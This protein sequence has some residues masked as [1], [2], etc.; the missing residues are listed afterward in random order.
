MPRLGPE[1]PERSGARMDAYLVKPSK[2]STATGWVRPRPS[3]GSRCCR[4]R[5]DDRPDDHG[6]DSRRGGGQVPARV[7]LGQL[8]VARSVSTGQ[9]RRTSQP[10][11]CQLGEADSASNGQPPEDRAS[12]HGQLE[13]EAKSQRMML[14]DGTGRDDEQRQHDLETNHRPCS[15]GALG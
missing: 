10:T 6:S 14:G 2:V 4:A 8:G 1:A 12:A 13:L 7:Y 15:S 5:H 3:A 11:R 9:S